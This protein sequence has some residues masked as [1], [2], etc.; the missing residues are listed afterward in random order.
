MPVQ[1]VVESAGDTM[2]LR[3]IGRLDLA[4]TVDFRDR[5]WKALA[6]QPPGIVVDLAGLTVEDDLPLTVFLAFA[7]K[8]ARQPG[9]PVV[10]CAPSSALRAG[11]DRLGVSQAVTVCPTCAQALAVVASAPAPS[12]YRRLLPPSPNACALARHVVAEA[13]RAWNLPGVLVDAQAV[14]T[15]LVANAVRH[16]GGDMRLTVAHGQ[17]YLHLS[18]W[19]RSPLAAVR[20]WPRP[21]GGRGLTVVEALSVSW[22]STPTAGGKVVW[23]TLPVDR[24]AG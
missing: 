20:M 1:V 15:E 11:L 7:G 22:G 2:V 21:R 9:C 12:R 17:R 19:D 24:S 10:L 4:S 5:L 14:V 16:A 13:C 6:Q 18:V 8:A 23:A 3:P